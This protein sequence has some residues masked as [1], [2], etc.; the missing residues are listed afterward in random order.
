VKAERFSAK[1]QQVPQ[2]GLR[3]NNPKY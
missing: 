2:G 1:V 3:P